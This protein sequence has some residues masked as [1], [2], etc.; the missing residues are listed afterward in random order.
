MRTA[1]VTRIC[2]FFVVNVFVCTHT[3]SLFILLSCNMPLLYIMSFKVQDF[4]EKNKHDPRALHPFLGKDLVHFQLYA[5][6]LYRIKWKY[7]FVIVF[8]L[9]TKGGLRRCA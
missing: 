2:S 3:F 4:K 7:D 6:Y 8:I 1:T 9:E 5:G